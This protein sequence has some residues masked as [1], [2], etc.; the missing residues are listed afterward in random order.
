MNWILVPAAA[1]AAYQLVSLAA[2]LKHLLSP[3]PPGGPLPPVSILK[4]VRGRDPHFFEAI[5]SHALLDYPEYEI[6]FGVRDADDP[7]LEDIRRLTA[8]FPQRA[9]RLVRG[10]HDAANGKVGLLM[11]LAGEAR[12]PVLVV[13]DS[14]IL[15]PPDYLQRVAGPLM[16][17]GVGIVTCLYRASAD[18]WAGRWEAL[19]IATGFAPSV[20][21]APLVGVR[22]FGLGSTLAFRAADLARIGGFAA[23]ADYLADDYQLAKR[24]TSLGGRPVMSKTVVE[25][26]LGETTWSG[27]WKHQVRWARTIR[28]SRGGGYAGLPVTHAGLWA[29]AAL[30]GGQP[31]AAAGLA[32]LRILAGVVGGWG[33]VRSRL[34][35]AAAPLIPLWDLWAFAVY[36]AGLGGTAVEWRGERLRLGNDGRIVREPRGNPAALRPP[37]TGPPASG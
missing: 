27:V 29:L 16:A 11:R 23:L 18:T 20:L 14:D 6:L 12:H 4:P 35:L 21:V 24:I 28:V 30:L 5:R 2:S 36:A 19:G 7:A 31:L 10:G 37:R 3:P 32:A 33:V 22:E 15:V 9:I 25:T 1:A 26:F 8:E 17:P 34:A 13:N